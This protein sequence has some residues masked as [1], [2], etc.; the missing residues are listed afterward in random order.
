MART[1]KMGIE[2]AEEIT[3]PKKQQEAVEMEFHLK[4]GLTKTKDISLEDIRS[5]L[6]S[7]LIGGAVVK[8]DGAYLKRVE[9]LDVEDKPAPEDD[10]KRIADSLEHFK[11]N[12]LRM[13]KW[14]VK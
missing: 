13:V 1:S 5:H 4:I 10:L 6:R 11:E 14:M 7:V 12:G 9:V 8:K 3:T 2:F